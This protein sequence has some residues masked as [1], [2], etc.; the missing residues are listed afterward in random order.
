METIIVAVTIFSII[1]GILIYAFIA[2]SYGIRKDMIG[3][4]EEMYRYMFITH[5]DAQALL[6]E[7]SHANKNT[8]EQ[9]NYNVVKPVYYKF[10]EWRREKIL[11]FP[12][13]TYAIPT[14]DECDE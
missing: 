5:D 3:Q 12:I 10:L 4:V 14:D 1:V 2:G 7:I 6:F 8:L 9:I 11:E 13:N